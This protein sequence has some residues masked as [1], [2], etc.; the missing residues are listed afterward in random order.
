[1][2]DARIP[3]V[4][5]PVCFAFGVL[6]G[7]AFGIWVEHNADPVPTP[8]VITLTP[9]ATDTATPPPTE[10]ASPTRT[11]TPMASKTP[12]ASR[13]PSETATATLLPSA[14]RTPV[15]TPSSDTAT[16]FSTQSPTGTFTGTPTPTLS[17]TPTR[18]VTGTSTRIPTRAPT[19]T[20]TATPTRTPRPTATPGQVSPDLA[21]WVAQ[22]DA[23]ADTEHAKWYNVW[24]NS[25]DSQRYYDLG[26]AVDGF[27]AMHWATGQRRYL[28]RALGYI[29]AVI[30]DARLSS[31][32]PTSQY[33]DEYLGWLGDPYYTDLIV[34]YPLFESILWRYVTDVLRVIKDDPALMADYGTRY[35]AILAFTERNIWDKWYNRGTS[36]IYRVR[37]HMAAH[38][39]YI[40]LNLETLTASSIRA[41]QCRTVRARIDADL[42]AQLVSN[43]TAYT[44][45]DEWGQYPPL[46]VQDAG[47]GN[48]TVSY[49]V[50]A[51]EMGTFW[52]EADLRLLA[53][54]VWDFWNGDTAAPRWMFNV[55]GSGGLDKFQV[56][57]D[58]WIKTARA[59][60]ALLA[61]YA[62]YAAQ[63]AEQGPYMGKLLGN[64]A[65]VALPRLSGGQ[66]GVHRARPRL[67][68]Q[69]QIDIVSHSLP[70]PFHASRAFSARPTVQFGACGMLSGT[71]PTYPHSSHTT[72]SYIASL[73][74]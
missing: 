2:S 74:A 16:P 66:S 55:D 30:A 43:G 52:T 11:A 70:S 9:T 38:W 14:T 21:W 33:H 67:R 73:M 28:D 60:P 8:I 25:G 5:A 7:M 64:G 23:V 13:T 46:S 63:R 4:F 53:G 18:T 1:M 27:T 41:A 50:R 19:K 15:R 48:H 12:T 10:T 62:T 58:G 32:L 26:Y 17:P 57:G 36:N 71:S 69:W 68:R 24:A 44:W 34:E 42:R 6:V 72:R 31:T 49:I 65:L 39:A 54:T 51:T 35:A 29:E 37:T 45:S 61:L 56:Q 59:D 47:H 40:A 3:A 20:P 22:F